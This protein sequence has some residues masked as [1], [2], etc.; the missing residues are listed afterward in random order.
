MEYNNEISSL[1]EMSIYLSK[2]QQD[3]SGAVAEAIKAQLAIITFVQSPT[4]ND[5]LLDTLLVRLETA[6][7]LAQSSSE[8]SNLRKCFSLMIQNYIFFLDAKLQYDVNQHKDEAYKLLNHAAKLLAESVVEVTKL[9]ATQGLSSESLVKCTVTNLFD[10]EGQKESFFERVI[11]WFTQEAR[12]RDKQAIFYNTI[13]SF[14]KKFDEHNNLIGPSIAI[15]GMLDRYA[16]PLSD[17]K[18]DKKITD[19]SD[20]K[21]YY[22]PFSFWWIVGIGTIL[23]IIGGIWSLIKGLWSEMDYSWFLPHCLWVCGITVAYLVIIRIIKFFKFDIPIIKLKRGK[24][25]YN[26]KLHKIANKY[27]R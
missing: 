11:G 12:I 5:T 17:F 20:A 15:K 3:S 4:L 18:F 19:I 26:K 21:A 9:C 7:S 23:A 6:I 13:E 14:Y 25:N 1:P 27:K 10:K 8:I 24:K 2:L 22:N 16:E